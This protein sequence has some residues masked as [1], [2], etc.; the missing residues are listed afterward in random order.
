MKR[1]ALPIVPLTDD[2]KNH[3]MT[4][5]GARLRHYF[6]AYFFMFMTPLMMMRHM[7]DD[8]D[9]PTHYER[10]EAP[11]FRHTLTTFEYKFYSVLF[12]EMPIILSG[13]YFYYRRVR[14][15]KKDAESGVKE[16]TTHLVTNKI[17][18]E[19][20]GQCYLT[21]ATPGYIYHEV[22]ANLYGSIAIGD[23]LQLYRA[24]RSKYI[25]G[26]NGKFTFF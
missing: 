10:S 25:F 3:L 4:I 18:A 22:D 20:T 19:H 11:I 12:A 21:L 23:Q 26:R 8:F 24:V 2:E 13:I 15:F 7:W 9:A 5:Y 14:P 1:E 6:W 17:Y 16:I